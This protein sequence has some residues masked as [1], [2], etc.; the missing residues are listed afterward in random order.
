MAS[1]PFDLGYGITVR[2]TCSV[3]WAA[4]PWCR[5]AYEALCAEE[6]IELADAALYRAKAMG[7]NQGVGIVATEAAARN[8]EEINLRSLLQG[9]CPLVQVI[10]TPCPTGVG[11]RSAAPL[12]A[13]HTANK[14]D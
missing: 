12:A 14:T 13:A 1:E 4:F 3:G 2:K 9:K 11:E 5:R 7:R 8:P 6:A 10:E